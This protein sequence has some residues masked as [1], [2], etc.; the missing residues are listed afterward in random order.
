MGILAYLAWLGTVGPCIHLPLNW[1][2][3][4]LGSRRLEIMIDEYDVSIYYEATK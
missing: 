1:N 2:E 4:N 3:D